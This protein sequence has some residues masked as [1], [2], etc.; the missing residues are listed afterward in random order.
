MTDAFVLLGSAQ[1]ESRHRVV[2]SL[3]AGPGEGRRVSHASQAHGPI[4]F[5]PDMV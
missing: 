1:L 4:S 5:K 2:A 3:E